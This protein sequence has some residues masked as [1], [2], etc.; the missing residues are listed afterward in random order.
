MR[1]RPSGTAHD[2]DDGHRAREEASSWLAR[3]ERG[4][5]EEEGPALREWLK[6]AVN[7]NSIVETARL[8]HGPEVM[9]VLSA[10]FPISP[11]PAKRKTGRSFL[12][13]LLATATAVFV[14]ALS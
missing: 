9:G 10:L 14:V 4:L 11:E 3:L 1:A 8:C 6:R 5:R 12:T 2:S 7:R 13:M